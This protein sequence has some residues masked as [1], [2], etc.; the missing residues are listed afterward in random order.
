MLRACP[1]CPLLLCC[2]LGA[3][4]SPAVGV[5]SSM[6]LDVATHVWLRG[7]HVASHASLLQA[8]GRACMIVCGHVATHDGCMWALTFV[9]LQ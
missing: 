9:K 8:C 7:G 5:Q 1:N 2:R 6:C 3:E 4:D